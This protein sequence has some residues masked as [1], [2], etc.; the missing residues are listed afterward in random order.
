LIPF[1][2]LALEV[3]M[4]FCVSGASGDD[5]GYF[6]RPDAARE[7]PGLHAARLFGLDGSPALRAQQAVVK[8]PGVAPVLQGI[9]R[10][11]GAAADRAG[12][13]GLEGIAA[14][15]GEKGR[16]EQGRTAQRKWG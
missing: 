5:N 15:G 1:N 4:F 13:G 2:I 7:V 11:A 9:H 16:S 6:H 14:I 10:H 3:W 8:V 12:S